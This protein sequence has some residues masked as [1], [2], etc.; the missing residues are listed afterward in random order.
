MFSRNT[1]SSRAIPFKRMQE[2][3]EEDPFIPVVWQ[4]KHKGMQ[5]SEY[6]E[7]EF[8]IKFAANEWRE[9]AFDVSYLAERLHNFGVTKQLCNRMLEP[10]MWHTALVTA[11]EYNNFF[12]LRLPKYVVK[13]KNRIYIASTRS[14]MKTIMEGTDY[15]LPA[16]DDDLG[17]LKLSKSGAEPHMQLLAETMKMAKMASTPIELEE[18]EWHIPFPVAT[19]DEAFIS[20]I[21]QHSGDLLNGIKITNDFLKD[22]KLM[23]SAARCARISYLNFDGKKDFYGDIRLATKLFADDHMS[24]FEH[25]AKSMNAEEKKLYK[26]IDEHG[27]HPR[28]CD[29]FTGFVSLRHIVESFKPLK[30]G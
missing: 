27:E 12:N 16:R 25:I 15:K 3:I 28:R 21:E 13:H 10:Y 5:G 6:I 1:A 26:V 8:A 20:L 19:D 29:N 23:I 7:D 11:T 4:K 14:E 9:S 18:D 30:N 24:P 17:W 22:L 2:M